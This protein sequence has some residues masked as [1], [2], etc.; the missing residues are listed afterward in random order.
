MGRWS[1][2]TRRWNNISISLSMRGRI[3]KVGVLVIVGK[4]GECMWCLC[5]VPEASSGTWLFW[6]NN[7][8]GLVWFDVAFGL[9]LV[10]FGSIGQCVIRWAFYLITLVRDSRWMVQC[11]QYEL[12]GEHSVG[13]RPWKIVGHNV[14]AWV[15]TYTC[16]ST[17]VCVWSWWWCGYVWLCQPIRKVR[18]RSSSGTCPGTSLPKIYIDKETH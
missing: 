16:E 3:V 7:G 1:R 18:A 15:A 2:S 10:T 17:F 9:R 5:A 11:K 13:F 14:W 6:E 12:A 4:R 8:Q